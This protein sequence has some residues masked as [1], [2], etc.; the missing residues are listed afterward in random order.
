MLSLLLHEAGMK[1]S[2]Y[3]EAT[4]PSVWRP[5]FRWSDEF[6]DCIQVR[7]FND[8]S[9]TYAKH[10]II[11]KERDGKIIITTRVVAEGGF[12]FSLEDIEVPNHDAFVDAI[13]CIR[14][15][16]TVEAVQR[17]VRREA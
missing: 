6:D 10:T 12:E 5:G 9:R 1:L 13:V 16:V 14:E 4:R 7:F 15:K 11:A 3:A 2:A 8:D 17:A